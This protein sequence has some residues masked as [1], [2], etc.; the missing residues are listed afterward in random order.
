MR[1]D[2]MS[3]VKVIEE[4][5]PL[6]PSVFCREPP[7]YLSILE[8]VVVCDLRRI[9][10]SRPIAVGI[11]LILLPARHTRCNPRQESRRDGIAVGVPF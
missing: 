5:R 10:A 2:A 11:F 8:K 4:L 9:A 7:P 3:L 1:L 6:T